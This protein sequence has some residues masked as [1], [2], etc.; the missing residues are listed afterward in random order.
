MTTRSP[1]LKL[2]TALPHSSTMPTPSWPMMVPGFIPAIVPRIMC[3]SVP[4]IALAVRR[5]IASVGSLIFGSFTSSRRTSP[6]PWNTIAR[7][8]GPPC[9]LAPQG[10]RRGADDAIRLRARGPPP[11]S[12]QS[13][14]GMRADARRPAR[15]GHRR[16]T[17]ARVRAATPA[18]HGRVRELR[19]E[20]L[21]HLHPHRRHHAL[22]LR[23]EDGR[24]ARDGGGV[25]ARFAPHLAG[26]GIPRA[27]RFELPDGRRAL[28]LGVDPRRSR[29]RLL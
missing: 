22:W 20:L 21:D 29:R 2:R 9:R 6:T 24:P 8:T 12:S 5:T 23:A 19:P 16:A 14:V 11:A 18:R 13:A 25:A 7:M 1:F 17:P 15:P 28:S 10:W 26:R 3:R 4:Q 27:A